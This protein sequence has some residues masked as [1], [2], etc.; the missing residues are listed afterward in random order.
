LTKG[1]D[2]YSPDTLEPMNSEIQKNLDI[3]NYLRTTILERARRSTAEKRELLGK[4]RDPKK[5][6]DDDL[7]RVI[8][9]EFDDRIRVVPI[10]GDIIRALRISNERKTMT[11]DKFVDTAIDR[12]VSNERISRIDIAKLTKIVTLQSNTV[13]PYMNGGPAGE[14]W[15]N[16]K[17]GFYDYIDNLSNESII[18][19][20][21]GFKADDYGLEVSNKLINKKRSQPGICIRLLIDGFVSYL[22]QK[23]PEKLEDFEKNTINMVHNMRNEGIIVYVNESW[24]PLSS[25][26]LA[27]NHMKMW[28]FDAYIA[29]FGGIGI[30]SQFRKTLYDEM[31]YV[32]GPFVNVLTIMALLL[33]LNQKGNLGLSPDRMK[34]LEIVKSEIRRMYLKRNWPQEGNI[35]MKVSMNVPGYVQDAQKDY[36]KLLLRTDIDEIYLMTPYF[37]DDSIARALIKSANYLY[38][39]LSKETISSNKR[40]DSKRNISEGTLINHGTSQDIIEPKRIHIIFPKKQE[41]KIIEEISRYYAYYLRNNPIVETR[42]FYYEH[43]DEKFEMLHAKQMIVVLRDKK[44]NWTKYV[45]FGGS[46]NPAGRAQNMW[47]LN[48][49]S[50]SGT[51]SQSDEGPNVSGVNPIK[52]Y[53]QN[54]MKMI[55]DKYSEPFPWGETNVKIS[56]YDKMIM[57]LSQLLWF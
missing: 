30:E 31:D 17:N 23:P 3:V 8:S 6:Y 19:I 2:T 27:A 15:D 36:I 37:S 52:S 33:M 40:N 47:E 5:V 13:T 51:W 46:Y 57:K 26:F 45:K 24:D 4:P 42:Q 9:E 49:I 38:R 43:N 56:I 41:D 53:L 16:A 7:V 55:V 54:V 18:G 44:K 50:I 21:L 28:V 14:Y 48:A 29:F 10:I 11:L 22:M 20:E 39:R 35:S 12:I 34:S 1:G 25:N 32:C